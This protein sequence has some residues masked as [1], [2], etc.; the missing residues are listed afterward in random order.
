MLNNDIIKG[1]KNVEIV[2]E[3]S[4]IKAYIVLYHAQI[5]NE[6]DVLLFCASINLLNTYVKQKKKAI[7]YSF[8]SRIFFLLDK[9]K[10]I[11]INN[12]K[13]CYLKSSDGLLIIKVFDIQ[14]S[15]H[16]IIFKDDTIARLSTYNEK[17]I[18]DGIR[19]QNSAMTIFKYALKDMNQTNKTKDFRLL[20]DVIN[21]MEIMFKKGEIKLS[22]KGPVDLN[23]N[24]V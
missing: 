7:T 8:K 23:G 20:S 3:V 22:K 1:I 2:D 13:I 21:D 9:L 15:Y 11:N 17:I 18:W 6:Y 24:F 4:V 19:K 10:E 12:V 16:G 14:F 5:L